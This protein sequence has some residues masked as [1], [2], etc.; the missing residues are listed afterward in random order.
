[1]EAPEPSLSARLMREASVR[2]PARNAARIRARNACIR[3]RVMSRTIRETQAIRM[4]KGHHFCMDVA[5]SNI[6]I[7]LEAASA[8]EFHETSKGRDSNAGDYLFDGACG[9]NP[10]A[11]FPRKVESS[12]PVEK[13]F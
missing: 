9:N 10:E 13:P 11:V 3:S 6:G 7:R 5:T 8:T 12:Q 1:M 2:K 4:T